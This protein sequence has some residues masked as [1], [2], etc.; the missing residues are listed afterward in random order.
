MTEMRQMSLRAFRD[1]IADVRQPVEVSKRDSDGNILVLGF[2]TPYPQAGSVVAVHP[3]TMSAAAL[4]AGADSEEI[5]RPLEI[6]VEDEPS[7]PH[8]IKT[9]AEAAAVVPINPVRAVPKP[10]QRRKR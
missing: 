7:G 5:H 1:T 2:W 8:V 3:S 9:P 4:D 10:G 6:P